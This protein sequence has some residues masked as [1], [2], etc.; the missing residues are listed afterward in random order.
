MSP[1]RRRRRKGSDR[2]VE[3][4]EQLASEPFPSADLVLLCG[5]GPD[6]DRIRT[7]QELRGALRLA[8][9]DGPLGRYL[10]LTSPLLRRRAGNRFALHRFKSGS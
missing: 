7:R 5:F 2:C 6:L 1:I 8:G 9:F 4:L 10:V 3:P